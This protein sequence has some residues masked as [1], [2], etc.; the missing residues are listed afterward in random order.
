[1]TVFKSEAARVSLLEHLPTFK[2]RVLALI[3]EVEVQTPFGRTHV[4]MAGPAD[5]P[6]LVA[7]HGAMASS[8]HLLAE[9]GPLPKT[10][11]VIVLDVLGQSPLSED[12]RLPLTQAAAGAWVTEVMDKLNIPQADLLGVSWGGFFA[13]RAAAAHPERFKSLT[14]LVPSGYVDGPAFEAMWRLA[15]PMFGWRVF[16]HEPSLRR[17]T[18][19]LFTTQDEAWVQWLGACMQ[20]LQHPARGAALGERHRAERVARPH[21]RRRR[22][23]R[24]QLPRRGPAWSVCGPCTP[25]SRPSW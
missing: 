20:Q 2:A 10:R 25:A 8:F 7:V 22:R 9:L 21:P 15:L 24:P 1:M 16:A 3:D 14:L 17:M 13:S 23:V 19:A 11:R 12:A 18:A 4:S 6:P 5:A